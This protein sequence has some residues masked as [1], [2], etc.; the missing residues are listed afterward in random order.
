LQVCGVEAPNKAAASSAISVVASLRDRV[1]GN[2]VELAEGT[3]VQV[4]SGLHRCAYGELLRYT[5]EATMAY[6]RVAISPMRSAVLV[7]RADT[8]I[9]ARAPMRAS[10][11]R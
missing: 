3:L 7:V 5:D 10:K 11:I 8:I 1:E 6:V 2:D 4:N 9:P